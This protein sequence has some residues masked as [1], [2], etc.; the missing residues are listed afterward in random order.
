MGL[1]DL[2]DLLQ[3]SSGQLNWGAQVTVDLQRTCTGGDWHDLRKLG[4]TEEV[5]LATN[6]DDPRQGQGFQGRALLVSKLLQCLD[7]LG[8]VPEVVANKLVTVGSDITRSVAQLVEV[9][10]VVDSKLSEEATA[11]WRVS[12]HGSRQASM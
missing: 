3:I 12:N 10:K 6:S 8:V 9:I 2:V 1:V 11:Q 4:D 5:L 7:S